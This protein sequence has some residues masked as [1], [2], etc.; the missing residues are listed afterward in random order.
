MYDEYLNSFENRGV[1]NP[2]NMG[3]FSAWY[4]NKSALKCTDWILVTRN[5]FA[6]TYQKH[7]PHITCEA[8]QNARKLF[9]SLCGA[10]RI[11]KNDKTFRFEPISSL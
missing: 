9:I 8:S 5:L 7:N 10:S 4:H 11:V 1:T 6:N 3:D 2:L